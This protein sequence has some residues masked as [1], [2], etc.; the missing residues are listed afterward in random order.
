MKR[1]YNENKE[2]YDIPMN[3]MTEEVSG[4]V[5]N[6]I[7]NGYG[8]SLNPLKNCYIVFKLDRE[9]VE[10]RPVTV[11]RYQLYDWLHTTCGVHFF[12]SMSLKQYSGN[13]MYQSAV[14][15]VLGRG[16]FPNNSVDGW[17]VAAVVEDGKIS[18]IEGYKS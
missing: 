14:D 18:F 5:L 15:F 2:R 10:Y 6:L 3:C 7:E 4:K 16:F 11:C 13:T 12:T 1:F 9:F 8:L 17:S